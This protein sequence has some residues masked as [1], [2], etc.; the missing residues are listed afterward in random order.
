MFVK[1]LAKVFYFF[2]NYFSYRTFR[3][4]I[5]SK[6]DC[7]LQSDSGKIIA[8]N[9]HIWVAILITMLVLLFPIYD[10]EKKML[11]ISS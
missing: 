4:I 8:L 7:M 9:A 2:R 6:K 1:N 3:K 10:F 5:N 11:C